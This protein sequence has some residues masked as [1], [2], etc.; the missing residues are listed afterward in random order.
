MNRLTEPLPTYEIFRK[1]CGNQ[2]S[3]S[4][5][6]VLTMSENVAP[7]TC[8]KRMKIYKD[9][10]KKLMGEKAIVCSHYGT[11]ESA[12][13]VVASLGVISGQ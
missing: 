9:H 4:V 6:L 12:W 11:K 2:Y 10:W 7:E 8:Q 1:L 13:E 5:A 3:A